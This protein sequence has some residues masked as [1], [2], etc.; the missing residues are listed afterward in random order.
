MRKRT[1][2]SGLVVSVPPVHVGFPW[3]EALG[4]TLHIRTIGVCR[5]FVVSGAQA[6]Q[7]F[8]TGVADIPVVE[9][10][11]GGGV[12][13]T[14]DGA[15]SSEPFA[16]SGRGSLVNTKGR[17]ASSSSAG[18]NVAITSPNLHF[19]ITARIAAKSIPG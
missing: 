11:P 17:S 6:L 15:L 5:Q 8:I 7:P 2:S 4:R 10:G 13:G 9:P 18:P 14:V 1:R 19:P 12:F 16:D 3:V